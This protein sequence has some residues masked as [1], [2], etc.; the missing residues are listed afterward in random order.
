MVDQEMEDK[1]K[2]SFLRDVISKYPWESVLELIVF[3]I[4]INNPEK[5]PS[6]A[7][8]WANLQSKILRL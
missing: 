6:R 3:N 5:M 4:L 2:W 1:S 8:W 7:K